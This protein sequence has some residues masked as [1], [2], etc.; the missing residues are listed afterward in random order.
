MSLLLS[1]VGVIL[2]AYL[3]LQLPVVQRK[4]TNTVVE[5]VGPLIGL[6]LQIEKVYPIFWKGVALKNVTA[7][8]TKGDTIVHSQWLYATI[9]TLE[10]D[11]SYVA[12]DEVKLYE[13]SVF[14]I[15]D[16]QGKLNIASMIEA[17]QSS[18]TTAPFRFEIEDVMIRNAHFVYRDSTELSNPE[19]GVNF[20]DIGVSDLFLQAHAFSLYNGSYN[21]S[22]EKFSCREQSGFT[23]QYLHTDAHVCDTL[24][25]CKNIAIY[26]PESKVFA[27]EYTMAFNSFSDFSDFNKKVRLTASLNRSTVTFHDISYFASPLQDLPYAFMVQGFVEGTVSDFSAKQL[28]IGY[29]RSTQFVG[30]V[31]ATGL[32]NIDSTQFSIVANKL[33]TN[34]Y[35]IAHTRIPPYAEENYVQLPAFM[36]KI[37]FCKYQGVVEGEWNNFSTQGTLL[38]NVGN[39]DVDATLK[40]G[41]INN[42]YGTIGLDEV[43]IS[44]FI[45]DSP[46]LGKS[47]GTINVEGAFNADSLIRADIDGQIQS[48]ECNK[49]AYSNITVEGK[50]TT[51]K[52]MGKIAVDDKNL[53]MQ[54]EGGLDMSKPIPDFEFMASVE[55]AKLNEINLF[56]DSLSNLSF[57]T[58]V[59][60]SGTHID[61]MSGD[62]SLY[63]LQYTNANGSFST[64]NITLRVSNEEEQR[65]MML[66]SAFVDA[67]V[68]GTGKY[69]DLANS[70]MTILSN[71][72]S[73]LPK[74]TQTS[75]ALSDFHVDVAVK[76]LNSVLEV[77]KPELKIASGT[78]CEAVY[79]SSDTVCSLL[80]TSPQCSYNS[81]VL[82][83]CRIDGSCSFSGLD[84]NV[85]YSLDSVQESSNV[86]QVICNVVRDSLKTRLKWNYATA[87][88]THGELEIHGKMQAKQ[89][90][91]LPKFLLEVQ[92]TQMYFS[93]SLWNVARSNIVVDTS[94][95]SIANFSF[96]KDSKKIQ[97]D[98]IISQN[99]DD[100]LV[101]AVENYDIQELSTLINNPKAR[102]SG[103]LHGKVRVKNIYEMPLI[104]ADVQSEAFS[105]NDNLLGALRIRSFWEN[106]SKSMLAYAS[107][108][109]EHAEV[110][111]VKGSYTPHSDSLSCNGTITSLALSTF[112]EIFYG[113]VNDISGSI[114]G[115]FAVEG[116]LKDLS[117]SGELAVKEGALRVAYTNVPY[118]FSGLL[119]AR[120]T[121]FFF[122]DFTLAD[123]ASNTA[124]VHGF[125]D[126]KELANP[127]YLIDV[128][129]PK[130]MAINTAAK[131]NDYFYGTVYY[132]GSAKIS[133]DLNETTISCTGKTL[134]NST[135]SIPVTYS[136]LSGVYDFLLFT[137]D[138]TIVRSNQKAVSTS[139]LTLDLTIDVTPDAL[140]QIIFDPK[141]GDII[142]ARGKGNLQVKMDKSGDLQVYGKYEIDE[143]DYLFTLKNLINKKLI[144]QKGGTIVWNGDPL[145]AQVDLNANYDVKAS[146]QPLF[147]STINASKRIA[148]TCKVN[149]KNNLLSPDISYDIEVPSTATQVSEVLATLSEDQKTL[150]FF[151]LLIQ[152]A[153]MAVNSDA[154]AGASVSFE[155]LSNQV[156]NLLSQIDPNLDVNVNYHLGT[157]E[158]INNEFEFGITRQFWH[159]RILV[160]VNGYT[161]F[162]S[163]ETAEVG[164][165]GSTVNQSQTT[166]FSGNVSVEM[167]LNKQGTFKVKGF[168]RSNDAVLTEKQENTQGVS[169]FITKDFNSFKDLFRKEQ[170]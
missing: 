69:K 154:M 135:I 50:F 140:A 33:V 109:N 81:I 42:C 118:T 138:T 20:N 166:D 156:R 113:T 137:A 106:K 24:I 75:V 123:H 4:L 89:Q 21:L 6:N 48:L 163:R 39:V 121:R 150:Q 107:I 34:P 94:S 117:Y 128:Q 116:V 47:S 27:K 45:E 18:D 87:I 114:G 95:I 8:N 66:R 22:I 161:D 25:Q 65:N 110:L 46:I 1:L 73:S 88:N 122:S 44:T 57:S 112:R 141:V 160:N 170:E 41:E 100:Y 159:D 129:S 99:K 71:H 82:N 142:K 23:V 37:T 30:E 51:R 124:A 16:S 26:T 60:F 96:Y 127:H 64:K 111:S 103:P 165:L 49:Y 32:P 19:V 52:F 85:L 84:F 56:N 3:V 77:L 29:G 102:L 11:S 168:S 98:G 38:T 53:R 162:G 9:K 67:K 93:D 132:A 63:D 78:H 139:D 83:D 136:E 12:L 62:V 144:I 148:V 145:N 35:D 143:G 10:L 115:T 164:G 54:F 76:N 61:D 91:M 97:V 36:Q 134:N 5:K 152:N 125:V 86:A 120:K 149:L 55:K 7:C 31:R 130:L 13:P 151:S 105:F 153:F 68:S 131:D 133:G 147:D 59:D 79:T 2:L 158:A 119:K 15:R 101:I 58:K 43:D 126:L 14:I 90:G 169:F 80:A 17:L 157:N 155:V 74:P 108:K 167:K 92:P 70:V 72:I 40:Q 104:F 146:P 28:H